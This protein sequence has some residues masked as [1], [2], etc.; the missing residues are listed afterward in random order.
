MHFCSLD[1]AW[2]NNSFSSDNYYKKNM[3][4]IQEGF[5]LLPEKNKHHHK[6][7]CQDII[8]HVLKCPNCKR[9][10]KQRL[11][12]PIISVV[13]KSINE[14]REPIVLVLITIFIVLL[15]NLTLKIN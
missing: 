10:L 11:C 8:K 14:Y 15:I 12:G 13:R 1:E 6:M 4:R 2:G 7:T 3:E 5:D 9:K